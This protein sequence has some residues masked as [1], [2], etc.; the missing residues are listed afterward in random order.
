MRESKNSLTGNL[1]S[2]EISVVELA[3]T[4]NLSFRRDVGQVAKS[5]KHYPSPHEILAQ[6][7][8][9]RTFLSGETVATGWTYIVTASH[10]PRRSLTCAAAEFEH[11]AC[12][13]ASLQTIC[14]HAALDIFIRGIDV[15]SVISR[16]EGPVCIINSFLKNV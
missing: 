16:I 15:V 8:R 2:H 14:G 13:P 3:S 5:G 1:S 6:I 12:K 10:D 9:S 7:L 4:L 11:Q